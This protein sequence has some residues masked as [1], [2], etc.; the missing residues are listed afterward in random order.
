MINLSRDLLLLGLV[1][2]TGCASVQRAIH[3]AQNQTD[4]VRYAVIEDATAT[5]PQTTVICLSF[6]DDEVTDGQ[7]RHLQ[8]TTATVLRRSDCG[9][10]RAAGTAASEHYVAMDISDVRIEG[11]SATGTYRLET[12]GGGGEAYRV[13]LARESDGE[14]RVVK[15]E[16]LHTA[17]N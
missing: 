16:G 17:A 3:G 12:R 5:W 15:K 6:G 1:V 10:W 11:E 4:L 13:G 2:G 7:I 14:W 8:T 9:N